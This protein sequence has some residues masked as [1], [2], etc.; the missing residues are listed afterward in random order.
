MVVP[1]D[2]RRGIAAQEHERVR[3]LERGRGLDAHLGAVVGAEPEPHLLVGL[4]ERRVG[5]ARADRVDPDPLLQEATSPRARRRRRSPACSTCSRPCSCSCAQRAAAS[6]SVMS[7]YSFS[8][9]RFASQPEPGR[10]RDE[11]DRRRRG[12]ACRA[13]AA[14]SI[15]WRCPMKLIFSMPGVP[16]ATP[17]H[18]NSACTGPPH[19]STA[20]SIDAVSARFDVDRLDAGQRDR[21]RS[22]SPRPP[23]RRPARARRSPR[24][25]RVAPPT[26][27][28]RLPS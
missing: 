24:P 6:K 17:A 21:R 14:R 23:R 19:S 22:P 25:S 4:R 16:S 10:R 28:T 27:R 3:L 9:G 11:A 18:E 20:A 7:R 13:R 26:T 1:R 12:R 5:R 15:R 8:S 2:R